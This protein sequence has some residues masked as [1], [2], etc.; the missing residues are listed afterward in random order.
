MSQECFLLHLPMDSSSKCSLKYQHSYLSHTL[1][2]LLPFASSGECLDIAVLRMGAPLQSQ[3]NWGCHQNLLLWLLCGGA[4]GSAASQQTALGEARKD[5]CVPEERIICCT[6]FVAFPSFY[7]ST[8][9]SEE[10]YEPRGLGSK[11]SFI[12]QAAHKSVFVRIIKSCL[13]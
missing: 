9:W 7:L 1:G 3:E 5:W 6:G 13:G 2:L 4:G 11:R 8:V 10:V 12:F